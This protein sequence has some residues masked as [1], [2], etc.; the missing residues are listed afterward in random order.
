MPATP[1]ATVCS[2][3]YTSEVAMT[4]RSFAAIDLVAL[5]S[6][7][8][9]LKRIASTRGGEYAG[10]W[11]RPGCGG[12][13]RFHVQAAGGSDGRGQWMCRACHLRWGDAAEFVIWLG[14]ANDFCTACDWLAIDRPPRT[15][16][17][18]APPLEPP[19]SCE[20]PNDTWQTAAEGF[21]WYAFQH[22]HGDTG[23][24]AL[25]WLAARG[26]DD[27]TIAW[28]C[29]GY[30]PTGLER[31]R[32]KWGVLPDDAGRETF[33]LPA[34][35]VIPCFVRGKLW[36][37][38]IRRLAPKIPSGKKYKTVPGSANAL[39]NADTIQPGTPALLCEGVFDALA[40][41]QVAGD[42][43]AAVAAGTTT[44]ARRVPWI[45]R[46]A[47]ASLVLVAMDADAGGEEAAHYWRDVLQH[48][49]RRW[50]PLFDDPAAMLQVGPFSRQARPHAKTPHA[51]HR[52]VRQGSVYQDKRGVWWYQPPAK[53]G[54]RLPRIRAASEQAARLAQKDHLAKREQ[55]VAVSDIPLTKEWFEFWLRE[56][57]A[58]AGT[59]RGTSCPA[60]GGTRT[61][62]DRLERARLAVSLDQRYAHYPAQPQPAFL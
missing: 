37:L 45:A 3:C 52:N 1:G 58:P 43:V 39:Y 59:V 55:G 22:L 9:R 11:P 38:S 46:L 14:L 2:T 53:D 47:T 40:V 62:G 6:Q 60:C 56:H 57:V 31:P 44:G 15:E 29:L 25:N 19:E 18:S 24:P 61:L 23:T 26:L 36:K 27:S 8:T 30:N 21:L 16:A 33:W 10:S 34:G 7:H 50:R 54:R 32:A 13:D 5:A 12:R 49:A 48:N 4:G 17:Y 41:Q 42:L 51:P 35:I 28:A 20:L